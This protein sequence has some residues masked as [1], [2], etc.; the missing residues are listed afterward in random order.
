MNSYRK[1]FVLFNMLLIGIVLTMMIGIVGIYMGN[2][3]YSDLRSTMEQI[4]MPLQHFSQPPSS[5][6]PQEKPNH[7]DAKQDSNILTVFY[8]KEQNEYS[9]LSPNTTYRDDKLHTILDAIVSQKD[10]FGT[11]KQ[12]DII[13]Y[14]SGKTPYQIAIVST[15]YITNSLIHLAFVLFFI[16]FGAMLLFLFISIQ[17]SYLA[18]KPL[19]EA[20]EREKQFVADASHDLKTPLSV[21]L[22]NNSILM[23]NQDATVGSVYRWIDSSQIAAKRMQQLITQMLKLADVERKNITIPLEEVDVSNVTMKASLQLESLAYEKSVT[24]DT[25]LIQSCVIQTNEDYLTQ[26]ISSLLENALKYEPKT[27]KVL[28]KLAQDKHKTCICVQNFGTTIDQEDLPHVFDRFYRSDKSRT[29]E[30]ESFGLGLAITR[31]M[32]NKIHGEIS[33][34]SNPQE[35]TIFTVTFQR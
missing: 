10:E 2:K 3:Y 7:K 16:W 33:V 6:P 21:I 4:V 15:S 25:E 20:M 22:A 24:L 19:E 12:Y 28:L 23:E 17:L 29:N 27:G 30:T 1:R 18:S 8:S 5:T 9:I 11:L 13:Y 35:G 26:I 34:T 31:E 32:V 14:R